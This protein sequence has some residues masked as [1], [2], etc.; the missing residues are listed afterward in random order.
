MM[1]TKDITKDD[2]GAIASRIDAQTVVLIEVLAELSNQDV[3]YYRSKYTKRY[4]KLA[5][6]IRKKIVS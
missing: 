2:V 4:D 6:K 3:G 5:A 1:K